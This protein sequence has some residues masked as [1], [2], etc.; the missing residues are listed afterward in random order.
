MK[1]SEH[2][3]SHE[4]KKAMRR[5]I[6]ESEL[7]S[8][9]RHPLPFKVSKLPQGN[10]YIYVSAGAK[11]SL[12]PPTNKHAKEI[13]D[14]YK[15]HLERES[16]I[17]TRADSKRTTPG[18]VDMD[19]TPMDKRHVTKVAR[20]RHNKALNFEKSDQIGRAALNNQ[21]LGSYHQPHKETEKPTPTR[22]KEHARE[23]RA[24]EREKW[25]DVEHR[26]AA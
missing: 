15:G 8:K 25:R 1:N 13:L 7:A 19:I 18:E 24:K 2:R 17:H 4:R 26:R 14:L 12:K 20:K 22:A 16:R 10:G 11:D 9:R 6:K 5:A 3:R 23:E 21:L